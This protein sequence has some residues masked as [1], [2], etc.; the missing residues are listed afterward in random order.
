MLHGG[1]DKDK[2]RQTESLQKARKMTSRTLVVHFIIW[3]CLFVG[4]YR[5][6]HGLR[7]SDYLHICSSDEDWR[8]RALNRINFH[9]MLLK[10]AT[11][12]EVQFYVFYKVQA[13]LCTL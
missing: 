6:N 11:I 1:E 10:R 8:K 9:N 2:Y 7:S 12:I 5:M 13:V 3:L 4:C